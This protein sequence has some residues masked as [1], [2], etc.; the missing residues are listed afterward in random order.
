[1]NRLLG[2]IVRRRWGNVEARVFQSELE[3][4]YRHK[5]ETEGQAAADRWRRQETLRT[6]IRVLTMRARKRARPAPRQQRPTR[7]FSSVGKDIRFGMRTLRKRPLFTTLVVG[8]LGLGIG[9]STI[10]FSLVDGVLLEEM[11]YEEPGELVTIWETFPQW[12]NDELLTEAWDK[13]GLTWDEFHNLRENTQV[14][15]DVAVHRSREMSLTHAGTTVRLQ[16]GEASPS[17]FPLLG[18]R[19][20]LGRVFLPGEE[21]PASPRVTILGHAL[22][23]SRFGADPTIVGK[24][25]QLN[26]GPFQVIGVLPPGFRLRSTIR[27]LL[28]S[29]MD[30]GERA[31]WV[32]LA[33]NRINRGNQDHEAVGRLL[34]GATLEQ[35]RA[36]LD[37][38]IRDGRTTDQLGFRLTRP[39]EEIVGGQRASL[40]LLLAA[41]GILLVIACANIAALLMS[42]TVGRTREMATRMALGAGRFRIARQLL[43]E[44][45]LLGVLGSGL[46]IALAVVGIPALL[47]LAPPLPRLEEVGMH[48]GVLLFSVLAGVGAG[49]L[50]GLA[51]AL[52]LRGNG[53]RLTQWMSG[54]GSAGGRGRYQRSLLAAELALTTVLL[55]TGGL[56]FRSLLNLSRVD[57]GFDGTA[58]ATVRANVPASIAPGSANRREI[59]RQTLERIEAIPGVERTGGIDG[60][61]FPGVVSGNTVRIEGR[62]SDEGG[63]VTA[64]N[65]VILP[66]YLEAMRIP[67]LAGRTFTEADTRAENPRLMLINEKMARQYW[68]NESPLGARIRDGDTVYEVVG[69]VGDV[70]ERHL[71]ED[72]KDMFYRA[73]P[74]TPS[75]MSIVARTAGDPRDLVEAMRQA[76]WD[77]HPDISLSQES[78]IAALIESSTGAERYR[79]MLVVVF[80]ILAALLAGVGVF[81]VTAHIVSKRTREMG[82]RMA[83]GGPSGKLI[84]GVVLETMVP[85][86]VGIVVGV[87]GALAV[88]R[89]LTGYLFGIAPWDVTTLWGM[90][91]LLGGLSACAAALP[92]RRVARVDPM[93]VL[94]EE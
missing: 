45:V 69:I 47:R 56:L 66:G 55:V 79:T 11:P 2:W 70:R 27:T 21:G 52:S 31:L 4:L 91:V 10:V 60:L 6:A 26:Q 72:P 25:I 84:R 41:A 63:A 13:I 7:E 71:A 18:V 16:V 49:V 32:P 78:T 80:G 38:L 92:A 90:A 61:P 37:A 1:M 24:T 9:A 64:R 14:F 35:A 40:R 3:E 20:L 30:T 89:L 65:H 87:F 73:G 53:L 23:S 93:S 22:W 19:P 57:P 85:G 15:T 5:V 43:T 48:H 86:G 28:S 44:S 59:F 75:T 42:E 12:R 62:S 88:S 51:P 83:L 81:G 74:G 17:L 82:I 94:R 50:F 33:L 29:A 8:T 46:G 34:P 39:K 68:P 76:V 36:E 54:R 67:L 58:V 77:V